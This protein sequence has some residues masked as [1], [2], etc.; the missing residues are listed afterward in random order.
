MLMKKDSKVATTKK[1]TSELEHLDCAMSVECRP[2]KLVEEKE[3]T[4]GW[5]LDLLTD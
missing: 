4:E 1:A 3:T 2:V 5:Q